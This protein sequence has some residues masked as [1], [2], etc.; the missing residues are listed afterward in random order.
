MVKKSCIATLLLV[1]F[2]LSSPSAMVLDQTGTLQE[3]MGGAGLALDIGSDAF[4]SNPALLALHSDDHP[5]FITSVSFS[6]HLVSHP[7]AFRLEE[8]AADITLSFL[9][10][11]LALTIQ[12]RTR[13]TDAEDFSDHT[14]YH[15]EK[16]TLF[17]LDWIFSRSPLT[18]GIT[19][20]AVASHTR[21]GIIIKERRQ[22]LD[23]IVQSSFARYESVAQLSEVSF[24][25]GLLLDYEWVKMGVVAHQF[26][27]SGGEGPL[28]VSGD[29]LLKTL[30]WGLALSSP[31]YNT[32]ND[33]HLFK[34]DGALDLINIGSNEERE[35]RLGLSVKLQLLPDWSVSLLT[36][37]REVKPVAKDLLRFSLDQ[38]IHTI[39]LSGELGKTT[40]LFS[41]EY[42]TAWLISQGSTHPSQLSV[43]VMVHL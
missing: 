3:A 13:F 26:A 20:Q 1:L 14:R 2:I 4:Y 32:S 11:S 41:Y 24:G 39:G 19:A 17:Q 21:D 33:L 27:F 29:S 7:G 25:L 30:S 37:Y 36:G 40:L 12:S 31:T 5:S 9:A 34:V 22:L 8:P 23:Y 16:L 6:D 43:A 38:G 35:L 15:G 18:V 28:S 42:P 10:K